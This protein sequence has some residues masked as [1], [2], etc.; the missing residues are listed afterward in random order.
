MP[1][2]I[3]SQEVLEG[4]A[5]VGAGVWADEP[6]TQ[7]QGQQLCPE[8]SVLLAESGQLTLHG[9]VIEAPLLPRALGRLVVLAPLLPVRVVLLLIRHELPLAAGGA[10]HP[11]VEEH[12]L[13]LLKRELAD[14]AQRCREVFHGREHSRG[15]ARG[16][17]QNRHH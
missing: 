15:S 5:L 4:V 2:E 14:G 12:G 10:A 8:D 6:K 11:A 13:A 16:R 7:L 3:N 1:S 9:E 17:T